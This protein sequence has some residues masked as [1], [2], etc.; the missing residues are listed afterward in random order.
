MEVQHKAERGPNVDDWD[1]TLVIDCTEEQHD[2]LQ[3]LVVLDLAKDRLPNRPDLG[4][5]RVLRA[6]S[7]GTSA[8]T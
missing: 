3:E 7:A 8:C 6:A 1:L 2:R 5:A 4:K